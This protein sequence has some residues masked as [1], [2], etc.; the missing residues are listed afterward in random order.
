MQPGLSAGRTMKGGMFSDEGRGPDDAALVRWSQQGHEDAFEELVR[1]HRDRAYRTALR[2]LGDRH[3]A[4]DVVQDAFVAAWQSLPRFR[5]D[6]A[7]STWLYRIVTN[8]ALNRAMRAREVPTATVEPP[9]DP[10]YDSADRVAQANADA[11]RVAAAVLRLPFE[12][13]APLVLRTVEGCSYE[14]VADI[15]GITVP[16]VKGRLHRARR[17]L[18]AALR[19]AP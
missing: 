17:D 11:D 19:E 15:L 18:A 3:D 14:E 12:Q 6:S 1:R 9:G 13:R 8:A 16:A 10:R 7:F 5:G 4:E 2:L